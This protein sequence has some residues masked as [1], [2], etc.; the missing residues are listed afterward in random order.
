MVNISR[1]I[2]NYFILI[3]S[4]FKIDNLCRCRHPRRAVTTNTWEE[5]WESTSTEATQWTLSTPSM[6]SQTLGLSEFMKD[7]RSN[8]QR[9]RARWAVY[10]TSPQSLIRKFFSL[11][12]FFGLYWI[13]IDW[14][15]QLSVQTFQLLIVI[16]RRSNLV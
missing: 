8:L 3:Y 14:F 6:A 7:S 2:V 4:D 13:L 10:Y 5:R 16:Y 12:F 11:L 9:E 1:S 15:I